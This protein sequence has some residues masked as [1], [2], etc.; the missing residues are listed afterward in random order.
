MHRRVSLKIMAGLL[1]FLA[2]MGVVAAQETAQRPPIKVG[3]TVSL[4]GQY[5]EFGRELLNGIE[6]WRDDVNVRGAL[7]GRKVQIVYYDD[8]SDAKTSAEL[9]LKLIREDRVDLLL[10]PYST[11][12]TIAAS[13][14]T[15]PYGIPMVT[16]GG[17]GSRIWSRGLRN[18]FG[19]DMPAINY[20]TPALELIEQKG[21]KRVALIHA[22]TAF[23]LE[24]TSGV[25]GQAGRLGFN[26][27]FDERYPQSQRNFSSL[28]QRLRATNPDIVIGGTYLDD[29]IGFVRAARA[30][31]LRPKAIVLTVGPALKDFGRELGVDAEGIMGVV[32]WMPSA[33]LARARDFTHR[34]DERFGYAALVHAALGYG[35]GQTLEA[36]VRLAGTANKNEVRKQL[37]EMRFR[38]ILGRYRVDDMGRQLDKAMFMLQWQD[39]HRLLVWPREIEESPVIFPLRR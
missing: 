32:Q 12:L 4:T 18:V 33:H 28:V 16:T 17:A 23:S 1:Y 13:S 35:G 3:V 37:R 2:A 8:K 38:S 15:E 26:V 7:L 24:V 27:V 36:A 10:G 22:D 34:Y 9:Y 21:L 31:G 14:A 5:E 30:Q 6:M 25:R 20:M 39:G 29:A 19:V 11:E